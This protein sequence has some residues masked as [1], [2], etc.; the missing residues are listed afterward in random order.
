MSLLIFKDHTA[1]EFAGWW[2]I[3]YWL[4]FSPRVA[5]S[6]LL[7]LSWAIFCFS[8]SKACIKECHWFG[9]SEAVKCYRYLKLHIDFPFSC[10]WL[11][12]FFIFSK[13]SS[14][15]GA[16]LRYASGTRPSSCDG[17]GINNQLD[18]CFLSILSCSTYW[19]LGSSHLRY[20][21]L[22]QFGDIL[23]ACS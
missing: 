18:R 9:I 8:V 2:F 16:R 23:S 11:K 14:F 21:T 15:L 13:C 3:N 4:C 12:D 17:G 10:T 22:K 20:T 5:R 6:S 1:S 7:Q 19:E